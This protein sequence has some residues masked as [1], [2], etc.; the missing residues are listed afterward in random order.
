M[1]EEPS[2]LYN[3]FD[4]KD[5][6]KFCIDN[7]LKLKDFARYEELCKE[8]AYTNNKPFETLNKTLNKILF[9]N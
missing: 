8:Y 9:P 2:R 1:I 6:I 4:L 3:S 5:K 7:K